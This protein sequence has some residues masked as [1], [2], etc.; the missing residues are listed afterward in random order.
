MAQESF[1]AALVKIGHVLFFKIT[2]DSFLDNVKVLIGQA[3]AVG[4]D[5]VVKAAAL[6]HAQKQW[7]ILHIVAERILH[8]IA[9]LKHLRAGDN[10]S[11][12]KAVDS[13][14]IQQV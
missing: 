7:T 5:N 10:P 8:F 4:F 13:S 11:K 6:V 9:I 3:A 1:M 2:E 12:L 14:F